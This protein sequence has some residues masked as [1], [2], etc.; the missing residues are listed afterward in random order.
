MM[1]FG[2]CHPHVN[3]VIENFP[4]CSSSSPQEAQRRL[5]NKQA[6][7][8]SG[9]EAPS[10]FRVTAEGVYWSHSDREGFRPTI[11]KATDI[12]MSLFCPR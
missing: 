12:N 8:T 5:I 7:I 4:E 2:S 9:L 11:E 3:T 6:H 1:A 10:V